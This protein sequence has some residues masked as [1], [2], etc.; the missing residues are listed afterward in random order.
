[1]ANSATHAA[2][3]YPI[4]GC[5]FTVPIPYLD[6]TGAPTDPVTPDTEISQDGGTYADCFEEETTIA[7][8]NGSAYLTLTGDELDASLVFLAAK[9]S[10]GPKNTLLVLQ[11]RV[12]PLV[13]SAT[14]VGGAA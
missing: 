3:P 13:R 10:S 9:V 7:G 1:M 14:A 8:A 6:A 12:L 2:L 11:P 5:R 4:R